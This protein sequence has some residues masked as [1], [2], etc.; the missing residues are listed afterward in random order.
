MFNESDYCLV[1][2]FRCTELDPTYENQQFCS[3]VY[4]VVILLQNN[5]I[6]NFY[7]EAKKSKQ[8]QN[9]ANQ[10]IRDEETWWATRQATYQDVHNNLFNG[11]QWE[12]DD[13][14]EEGK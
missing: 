4:F 13:P 3:S 11:Q 12:T 8:P 1:Y 7:Q 9:V 6:I 2:E 14:A 5:E 10:D